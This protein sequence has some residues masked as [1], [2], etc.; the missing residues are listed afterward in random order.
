MHD[1]RL[2]FSNRQQA[3]HPLFPGVHRVL[4]QP[5]GVL[6]IGDGL[7][8]VL[9]AQVCLDRRGL[10][11]QVP[12]GARGVHINGRPVQRMATLRAGDAVYVDGVELRVLAPPQE[13]PPMPAAG[14]AHAGD[15]CVVLRGVGG[16]HH[17]RSFTLGPQRLVGAARDA[18]IRIDAPGF[19]ARHALLERRGERVLL[20]GLSATASLVNGVAMTDA[21]L[22]AGD[23]VVFDGQH[24]FVLEFPAAQVLA[25]PT[26]ESESTPMEASDNDPAK[27]SP[28]T[29]LPW[30]LL[31]ALL[32]GLVLAALLWFGAR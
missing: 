3:D 25:A 28:A 4:R 30:L 1:L 14:D 11:L 9:L 18:D 16:Q 21:V 20:R 8:G 13:V 2:H 10:W 23:Q 27:A 12:A 7:P 32:L 17:G 24:R 15:P 22:G 31:A 29:R 19:P 26:L 5:S 6:G